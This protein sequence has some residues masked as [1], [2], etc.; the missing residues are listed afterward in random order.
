MLRIYSNMQRGRGK[1]AARPKIVMRR[2]EIVVCADS[3]TRREHCKLGSVEW[4]QSFEPC[5]DEHVG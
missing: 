2:I 4:R 1:S 3:G 5:T